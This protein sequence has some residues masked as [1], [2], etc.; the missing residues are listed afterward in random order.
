SL[1]A[2]SRASPPGEDGVTREHAGMG[3]EAQG[4]A[5]GALEAACPQETEVDDHAGQSRWG[6]RALV[7]PRRRVVAVDLLRLRPRRP[8]VVRAYAVHRTRARM[9]R[10]PLRGRGGAGKR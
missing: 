9:D 1:A 5:R 3:R 8:A 2:A 10:P 6:L 4:A 7:D